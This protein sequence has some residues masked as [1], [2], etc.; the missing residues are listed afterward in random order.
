MHRVAVLGAGG[1]VGRGIVKT[2]VDSGVSVVAVRRHG[3]DPL[4][5]CE[6]L[7]LDLRA[8]DSA[9][10][11]VRTGVRTIIS[12]APIFAISKSLARLKDREGIRIVV[13]SSMSA[14]AKADSPS[15]LD[16]EMA[17][18]LLRAETEVL[19]SCSNTVL[20]RPTMIYGHP[21]T[22]NVASMQRFARRRGWLVAPCC[23]MGGRQPIHFQ[24]VVEALIAA[25]AVGVP[26]STYP[27]GGGERLCVLDL[28][29]RVAEIECARLVRVPCPRAAIAGKLACFLGADRLGGI[30]YRTGQDQFADNTLAARDLAFCPRMFNPLAAEA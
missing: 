19:G 25:A 28:L 2:L 11:L 14:V 16:R 15:R 23:A 1:C 20:V 22:R 7:S 27:I 29:A 4:P 17:A 24:D 9:E 18:S 26:R 6:L 30:V 3:S 13:C 8:A 12:A 5:N 10:S 21:A